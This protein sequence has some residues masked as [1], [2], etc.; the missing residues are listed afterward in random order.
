MLISK[1]YLQQIIKEEIQKVISK[2]KE[3]EIQMSPADYL[4]LT[5][6]EQQFPLTDIIKR[7]Q[8]RV[9][10]IA[11]RLKKEGIES[12]K[13]ISMAK[14][15]LANGLEKAKIPALVINRDGKVIDHEGRL[16]SYYYG[17]IKEPKKDN[18]DVLIIHPA[19]LDITSP[20]FILK[21]QFDD[22][23]S[24]TL[25]KSDIE[26]DISEI[27]DFT[28]VYQNRLKLN[29]KI[30]NIYNSLLKNLSKEEVIKKL[31]DE[32]QKYTV[33][34]LTDNRRKEERPLSIKMENIYNIKIYN[35]KAE[36]YSV[37]PTD[38]KIELVK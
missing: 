24:I 27:S 22:E 11:E 13:A 2:N 35:P 38:K 4:N 28:G 26:S 34:E 16:R 20:N 29:E 32:L 12:D 33:Y 25:N 19:N 37:F 8:F 14:Q 5:T 15:E 30:K 31:N 7:Y 6:H 1:N 23:K 3:T 10:A 36:F 17:F 9:N 21:N 18:I